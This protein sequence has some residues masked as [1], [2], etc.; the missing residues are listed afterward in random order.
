[1]L[2]D[3]HVL[4]LLPAYALG[5]LDDAET[6]QVAEHL[7]SCYTCRKELESYQ[8]VADM[9]LLAVP[10]AAPSPE[11]KKRLARRLHGSELKRT[12]PARGWQ[13]PRLFPVGAVAGL[14]ILLLAV[15]NLVLWQRLNHLEYMT[16]PLGM[17]AVALQNTGAAPD[18]SAFAIVSG[19]GKNGVLV[20]DHLPELDAS[21]EYQVWLVRDGET[22]GAGTFSV[23]EDGYRGMRLAAPDS[24]LSYASVL[25]TVEPAGGSTAPT[26]KQVLN[27]SLFNP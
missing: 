13:V 18:G 4:E 1:M 2:N 19:D 14:L 16:G 15:S 24:L 21:K 17:K 25:V 11:L 9:L 6:R 7:S 20:V 8:A 22:T 12:A 5:S 10:E 3:V 27:G 23:D 26:G